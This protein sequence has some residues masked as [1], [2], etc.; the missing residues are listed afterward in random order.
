MEKKKLNNKNFI[1][2]VTVILSVI[3][4]FSLVVFAANA[5]TSIGTNINTGGTLTVSG[6]TTLN[7]NVTLGDAVSDVLTANGYF[8]QVRIG[9]GSTF[10]HI[11]TVGADE[12]GVEG[13]VE[14][15]GT[16]WFDGSLRASST[17]L[18]TGAA[19]FYG[20]VTLGDAVS[21]IITANGYFT[22][23]RIGTGSS[24]GH[25]GTVGADELGVEGDIEVDGTAW[26]DGSLRASSTLLATGAA[27][28]YGNVTLGDAS[29]DTITISGNASTSAITTSGNLWVN[30]YATTTASNGNIAT[31]GTLTVAGATTLS[32]TLNVSGAAS[33]SST[34]GVTGDTTLSGALSANGN[35]SIG[36]ANTDTLTVKAGSW[37]FTSTAT[38]TVSMTNGL[39]FD[40]GTL[41]IDPNSGRVGLAT[42][43]PATTLDVNG[44]IKVLQTSTTT[45]CSAAIAGSI[46]YN[47]ANGLFW[48]CD[49]TSWVRL[50]N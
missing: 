27:S 12:L 2:S 38:T 25:I 7:G 33:L 19:N 49:G 37:S 14:I 44:Y 3:T 10:G 39:N 42:A 21:D 47:Q 23:L 8:T 6:A 45:A 29:S 34:L 30:G 43:T 17:L 41:V 40:A 31:K 50:S 26:F 48:G 32:S 15:D 4:A 24:F 46:F 28:F 9:T 11:G 18:A 36:D 5:V 1:S 16:A 35:V 13:N 20:N 22:Q